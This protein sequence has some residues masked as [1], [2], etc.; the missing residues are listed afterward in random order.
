MWEGVIRV[1]DAVIVVVRVDIVAY[2]VVIGVRRS[3]RAVERVCARGGSR[4]EAVGRLVRVGEAV[5][6]VVVV[7]GVVAQVVAIGVGW[8]VR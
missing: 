5:A 8:L 7:L 6:V 4:V 2:S 3:V 1:C